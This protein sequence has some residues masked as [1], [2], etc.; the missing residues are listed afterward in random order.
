MAGFFD[1]F[2]PPEPV[3]AEL[4]QS[5]YEEVLGL[6]RA[7]RMIQGIKVIRERTGLGLAEAKNLADAIDAG[8]WSPAPTGSLADRTRELLAEDRVADAVR[9]VADETGM[10]EDEASRF[11]GS[12]DQG[13]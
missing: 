2:R 11:I 4:D 7:N 5:G 10:T 8:R 1:R 12:L 13:Q 3:S 9:M 6:I